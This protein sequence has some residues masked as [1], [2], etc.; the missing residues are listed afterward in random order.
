MN[1]PTPPAAPAAPIAPTPTVTPQVEPHTKASLSTA[2]A[3][4]M[5]GWIRADRASG[6]M[7]PEQ[8]NKAFDDLGAT[9]EQR[10]PD[11]RNDEQKMLDQVFPA[12]RPEEFV[13]RWNAVGDD[14]PMSP[15]TK[16]FDAK[17]RGWLTEMGF[18]RENGNAVINFISKLAQQKMTPAQVEAH[19]ITENAKLANLYKGTWDEQ[20]EPASRM[21][22]EVEAKLPGLKNFLRANG[23]GDTATIVNM[24]IRQAERYH[25]RKKAQGR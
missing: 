9:E 16:I 21:I 18:S 5:G 2:E 22:H 14:T 7:T 23:V 25:A 19:T 17:A 24:L 12:A 1:E 15:E 13:I 11:P 20:F 3:A 8:A 6:K 10:K 4:T